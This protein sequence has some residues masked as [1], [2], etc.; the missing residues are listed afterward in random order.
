MRGPSLFALSRQLRAIV[1]VG[2]VAVLVALVGPATAAPTANR[3]DQVNVVSD[4]PGM[5]PILDPLLVNPWG[6][7]LS[8]TS[9]LWVANNGSGTATLYRGDGSATPFAKVPLEVTVTNG[10]PTGQ[11]FND[12]ASFVVSTALG[13]G[14]ARFIFDSQTGDITGWNPAVPPTVPP[15]GP[16]ASG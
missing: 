10:A 11:V 13:S 9:P 16:A 3:F 1:V 7:A 12:T 6:L 4:L 8:P 2:L 15:P 14:P 5:A